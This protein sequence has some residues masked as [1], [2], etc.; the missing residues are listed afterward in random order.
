MFGKLKSL[1]LPVL[2]ATLACAGVAGAQDLGNLAKELATLRGDVET[3]S[4]EL[5]SNKGD[6]QDELRTMARQ[7]TELALELDRERMRLQKVRVAISQKQKV[8]DEERRK[9]RDLVPIFDRNA[10][11][12][13]SYIAGSLPFRTEERLAELDKIENQLEAGLLTPQRAIARLW[14]LMEDELRMTRE[15]GL[16]PQTIVLD[17]KEQ[18]ADVARIGMVM[19]FFRTADGQ[20]GH[21]ARSGDAWTFTVITQPQQQKLVDGLFESFKKQIRVGYFTLPNPLRD[22]K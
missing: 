18:L 20:R 9:S 8:V 4:G 6:L 10:D 11:A 19:L 15:S 2:G 7:E 16:F 3:L 22:L 17:G 5:A 13:R 1:W 14:T 12:I 21:A